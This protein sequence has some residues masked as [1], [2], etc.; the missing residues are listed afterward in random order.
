MADAEYKR[1]G[2]ADCGT[3]IWKGSTRCRPCA[4]PPVVE[5]LCSGC[6]L[7][8]TPKKTGNKGL[9]C[10]RECA[11]KHKTGQDHSRFNPDKPT[12]FSKIY[13]NTCKQCRKEWTARK[14][15]QICSDECQKTENNAKAM[16]YAVAQHCAVGRVVRCS[17]CSCEYCPLYGR[18]SG[19]RP[20]CTECRAATR[21]EQRRASRGN[22]AHRA[23]MAGTDHRYFNEI[24]ILERDGWRCKL[25]GVSTPKKLRGT[26]DPR[27][28]EIDHIVPIGAGGGHVKEN[29]Q[30]A[31]RRCN[32]LKGSKPRGQL[33]LDGFA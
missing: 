10:S 8:F 4:N 18:K 28:P 16:S 27:A 12:P 17:R 20:L 25:C 33:I 11:F 26:V 21:R 31:C 23:K 1:L 22:N 9:Y 29:V 30:C 19:C 5:R 32:G 14:S 7:M 2:C 13:F 6:G 3:S 24:K 15:A